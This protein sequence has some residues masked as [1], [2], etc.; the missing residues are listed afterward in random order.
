MSIKTNHFSI[1]LA[2]IAGILLTAG[3]SDNN[4]TSAPVV[5]EPT[6]QPT[7]SDTLRDTISALGNNTSL[8][9]FTLPDSGD[10]NNIPQDPNNPITEEKV[11]LGQ[12][13][14]HETALS[15]EGVNGDLNGTWSCASCHHV[16]AGFKSGVAQGIGEGGNG[17]GVNGEGRTLVAGFDKNSDNTQ[18][19]PDVQPLTSP[20]VLNA[21]FQEVMLWNGQFGNV[22]GGSINADLTDAVL[23]P[24]GTPKAENVRGFAGLEIQAIA[25]TDVHRLRMTDGSVLQTNAEYNALFDAAYPEGSADI[26]EDAG[27]AIAA[28]ERTIVANE[29]PFQRWLKGDDSAMN[30]DEIRGAT[31]FFGKAQCVSCHNGPALSSAPNAS[32][33]DVFMAM[34]FADFD[35]ENADI[36]GNVSSADARGRGGFTGEPEDDFK[37]KVPQLYNLAD[38]NI[39]GHGA[40]FSTI[41]A[42]VE[43]KN[44]AVPQKDIP[45]EKMDERFK[46][47]N[48]TE[49]EIT[50]LASFL[51]TA[52]YDDNLQRYVPDALPTEACFPVA[53]EQ[54]KL[55]MNCS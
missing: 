25:G 49:E 40:S 9:T 36:T 7:L 26:K 46:P 48:L 18:M 2:T 1:K 17:F 43:Y 32:E 15:T 35:T 5:T 53:D 41:R 24:E 54:S 38:T 28:F 22:E 52:L 23:A 27:K 12:M 37:F 47:L 44:A 51:E 50:W 30:D 13:L 3:C 14:F 16:A 39:F 8:Q 4:N 45:A 10:Y 21:A 29:A 19:V 55:D 42:V 33:N 11:K 31:L 20:A 6:P 34:A